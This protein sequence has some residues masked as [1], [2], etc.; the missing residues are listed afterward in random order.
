MG[1]K[2]KEEPVKANALITTVQ[3]LAGAPSK[4]LDN[5]LET[6]LP[7]ALAKIK[8]GKK[9]KLVR[10]GFNSFC[11][12]SFVTKKVVDDLEI[13]STRTDFL[14]IEGFG[15]SSNIQ[16]M[17]LVRFQLCPIESKSREK[18][19]VKAHVQNGSICS[20]YSK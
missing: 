9:E 10:V 3:R 5:E 15:G 7:T 18:F 4:F 17:N 6:L 19:H 13:D 11:Q 16:H 14:N 12:K 20:F 1:F 8:Y 2:S